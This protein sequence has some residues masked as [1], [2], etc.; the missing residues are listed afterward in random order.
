LVQRAKNVATGDVPPPRN[1]RALSECKEP[2]KF[3]K[4][5]KKEK[6][7]DETI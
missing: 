1:K 4:E 6:G 2:I 5:R 7:K 3:A